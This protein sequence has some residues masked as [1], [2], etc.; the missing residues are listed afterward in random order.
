MSRIVFVLFLG[1]CLQTANLQL[2][3]YQCEDCEFQQEIPVVCGDIDYTT[4]PPPTDT[5]CPT[6]APELTPPST[7]EW[8][9]STPETTCPTCAPEPT[10]PTTPEPTTA[11]PDTTC[12]TC[13]P[14][15]PTTPQPTTST[16]DT[17]CPTCAP[18]LPTTPIPTTSTPVLTTPIPTT[19][20]PDT[21]CPTCAPT[22][23]TTPIPT[24]ST[25]VPTTPIPTTTTPETTCP[26]CAPPTPT[27]PTQPPP[28]LPTS[29]YPTTST[30]AP[31]TEPYC[32]P[33][34]CPC[35]SARSTSIFAMAA[36]AAKSAMMDEFED[37]IRSPRQL[38]LPVYVC[39]TTERYVSN[40]RVISRGCTKRLQALGDTCERVNGGQTYEQCSLCSWQLCNR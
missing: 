27:T 20:T 10:L 21:T 2:V 36:R 13:A 3:C 28:T 30:P 12:P 6:C 40:R 14:T 29:P 9:T 24:T 5:T 26:T 37:E 7:P 11:T 39:F 15:L 23:P 19:S 1:L 8:T 16:P 22:L 35:S 33:G 34:C 25:P 32:P 4:A 17:T 18:T 38:P 31:T